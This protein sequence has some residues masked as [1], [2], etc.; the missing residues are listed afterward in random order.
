M[1][2]LKTIIVTVEGSIGAGKTTLLRQLEGARFARDHVVVYEPVDD[3]MS[4]KPPGC[5]RSVFEMYYA[6]K[7]R[8]GFMFQMFVLQTRI[9]HLAKVVQD[10]P[11][12]VIITERCPLTDCEIFAKMLRDSGVL[13]PSEYYVYQH[14]YDFTRSMCKPVNGVVYLRVNAAICAERIALRAR[15]GEGAIDSGYLAALDAQH[16]AWL[17][18]GGR[19]Q[20]AGLPVCTVDGN[21]YKPLDLAP[22]AAFI[23]QLCDT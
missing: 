11:G 17:A 20:A 4:A 6:D 22:I 23:K 5:E 15:T 8:W 13:A 2:D 10:N 1:A 16:E 9:Q 18:P 3:W 12:K 14:W 19:A 21:A 7:Y